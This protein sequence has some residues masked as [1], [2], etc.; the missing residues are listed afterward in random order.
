MAHR[1]SWRLAGVMR[2]ITGKLDQRQRRVW[3]LKPQVEPFH[4][5]GK[6]QAASGSS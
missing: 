6:L 1:Q 5:L 4:G 2:N 3:I